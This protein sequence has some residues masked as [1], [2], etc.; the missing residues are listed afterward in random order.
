MAATNRLY[1]SIAQN[2]RRQLQE[3]Q[4]LTPARRQATEEAVLRY[5][6]DLAVSLKT[7]NR[8]FCVEPF[9]AACG[10]NEFGKAIID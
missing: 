7:D 10:L 8:H 9:Y 6:R 2:V 4:G 1:R 3:A 5:T